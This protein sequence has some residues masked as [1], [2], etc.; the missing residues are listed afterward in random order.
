M[1][2]SPWSDKKPANPREWKIWKDKHKAK[3]RKRAENKLLRKLE[4]EHHRKVKKE[5]ANKTN[6]DVDDEMEHDAK[7]GR[8]YTVSIA[9]PGSI[10]NNAQTPEL[11]TYLAGQ[12]AR[13]AVVFNVDEIIVFDETGEKV[14]D[15]TSVQS[16]KGYCNIQLAHLLQYLECPQYLRKKFFPMHPNLKH[17]GV[18]NPLDCPSHVKEE[19]WSAYREGIILEKPVKEG[20]GSFVDVGL[21][22][23]VQVDKVVQPRLRVTVK[24]P[25]EKTKNKRVKGELVDNRA[26]VQKD[27]IYW[28]YSVRLAARLSD[29]MSKSPYDGGY[30]LTIGTSEKGKSVDQFKMPSFR[31]L[32]VVFGGVQGLESSVDNDDLLTTSDPSTLFHHYLNTCPGQG[33]RT[34]R[35]E[36]AVSITLT[37]LRPQIQSNTSSPTLLE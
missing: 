23:E 32:L 18:V 4:K 28:G 19:E 1:E 27:G 34:I 20:R 24:M 9:L 3:K 15:M 30:D 12:I 2:V 31:H 13:T 14:E 5:Q 6:D 8:G 36:E 37:T 33:S 16:G 21:R 10:M 35:T 22:K 17:V 26:P 7:S 29:V 11:R 25:Q